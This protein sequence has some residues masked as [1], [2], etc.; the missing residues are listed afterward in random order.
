MHTRRLILAFA[1][2]ILGLAL[3]QRSQLHAQSTTPPINSPMLYAR[4][5]HNALNDINFVGGRIAS[6]DQGG[7][8]NFTLT[9][10]FT[11][12]AAAFRAA[13]G[14]A[15]AGSGPTW[16]SI[17]GSLSNQADLVT[18]LGLKADAS[19]LAGYVPTTRTVNGHPL[20]ANVTVTAADVGAPSGSGTSSGANSGDQDLSGLVTKVTQVNGHALSANVTVTASDVGLGSVNNTSDASKP[21]STATQTALNLKL[22]TSTAATTYVPQA[23]QV[24]GHALSGNVTVTKSDVSLGNVDNTSDANKPVSTAQQAALD[25]KANVNSPSLITPS[26]GVATATSLAS[27]GAVSAANGVLGAGARSGTG[28]TSYGSISPM[29]FYVKGVTILTAGAANTDIATI[30]LPTGFS[31]YFPA[32]AGAASGGGRIIVISAAG[33]FAGAGTF[34]V[35]DAANGGGGILFSAGVGSGAGTSVGMPVTAST[36]IFTSSTLY[37]NQPSNSANAG[38]CDFA[39]TLWPVP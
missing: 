3:A 4:A 8:F 7:V 33:T 27:V 9:G 31:R 35:R 38:T 24:N 6:F 18:A 13:I 29:T 11:G 22:D 10:V 34:A 28:G 25:L 32:Q 26:L 1:L 19:A 20:S 16:G 17:T 2:A 39:F 30:V 21:V 5:S 36:T 15:A 23:T 14:A 12:N 37:I